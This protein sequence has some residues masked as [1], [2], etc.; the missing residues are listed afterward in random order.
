MGRGTKG[1]QREIGRENQG[2]EQKHHSH[3]RRKRV[4]HELLL[5]SLVITFFFIFIIILSI[6]THLTPYRRKIRKFL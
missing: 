3:Q 1:S 4:R 6:F 2:A 5:F